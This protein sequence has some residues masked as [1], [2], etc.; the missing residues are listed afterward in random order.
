DEFASDARTLATLLRW[1]GAAF[2]PSLER[3]LGPADFAEA[4]SFLVG[5]E[6]VRVREERD[7][8]RVLE[9]PVE[10]RNMLDFYKNNSIHFFL[11]PSLVAHAGLRGLDR[12]QLK[13]E[14]W[15]WLELFRWEFALPERETASA[16][17]GRLL[18]YF[19]AH[20]VVLGEDLGRSPLV[21]AL[22]GILQNFR[23]AYWVAARTA[24]EVDGQLVPEA[25]LIEEMRR[26][27]DAA[28]LLGEVTKPE[29]ASQVTFGNAVSRFVEMGCLVREKGGKG[30]RERFVR[31]GPA[32]DA[33]AGV[34]ARLR[35]SL[36]VPAGHAA[37]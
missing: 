12:A 5:S 10:K 20:G 2:T 23:E 31:R 22:A 4:T 33:L 18:D 13:E 37:R 9:V 27:F 28:V 7:G 29:G 32:F 15:W 19:R 21:L 17:V 25:E 34:G 1:R 3:N 14:L 30:G 8:S 11:F 26:R 24:Q 36:P 6:L 16:E 35:E